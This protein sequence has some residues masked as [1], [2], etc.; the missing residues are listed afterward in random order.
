[1]YC[2][3]T[4]QAVLVLIAGELN[5]G[6]DL[7]AAHVVK[8]QLARQPTEGSPRTRPTPQDSRGAR[9]LSCFGGRV[10]GLGESPREEWMAFHVK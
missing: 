5:M 7:Q 3:G 6:W 2:T 10:Y 8:G 4:K 1:M 9:L